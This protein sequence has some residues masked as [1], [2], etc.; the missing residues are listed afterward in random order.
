M[1]RSTATRTT[2]KSG[3]LLSRRILS[4]L[5]W[6][7]SPVL[8]LCGVILVPRVCTTSPRRAVKESSSSLFGI[9]YHTLFG[10]Y[11][12]LVLRGIVL[13]SHLKRDLP[14]LAKKPPPDPKQRAAIQPRYL[15]VRS[16]RFEPEA[17]P[18]YEHRRTRGFVAPA[19]EKEEGMGGTGGVCRTWEFVLRP[20]S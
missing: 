8:P 1:T 7:I 16:Y 20:E 6:K 9:H 14:R 4:L 13:T 3:A 2:R 12:D 10:M 19:E 5:I 15:Q 17:Y 11:I 18:G